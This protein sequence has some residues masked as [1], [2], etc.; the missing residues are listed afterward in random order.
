MGMWIPDPLLMSNPTNSPPTPTSTSLPALEGGQRPSAL[1]G[2]EIDPSGVVRAPVSP[3]PSQERGRAKPMNATS[4]PSS[5]GSSASASLQ[6]S[7]ESRLRALLPC[8][9][10][11]EYQLTWKHR[12]TPLGRVI[13]ALRARAHPISDNASTGWPTPSAHKNTK[14]SKDPQCMK[15]GGVQSSLADAAWLTGW[16]T[17]RVT[18]N[19]GIPCPEHT[20]KGSRLEDQA[21][22]TGWVSPTSQDGS[23]GS[24]PPRPQDSGVPLSQ[25]VAMLGETTGSSTASTAKRGALAPEFSRWLMGFPA[26]WDFCG[27]TAM[28]SSRKSRPRSSKRASRPKQASE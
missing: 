27:A 17:P 26:G 6:S 8:D 21:A 4:G 22:L 18:T 1:L 5:T 20:G 13:C 28:Q 2:G 16:G 7:L 10:S 19:G 24:L 14:N 12:V 15:E 11:M 3:F 23:R 25:Q 9:G